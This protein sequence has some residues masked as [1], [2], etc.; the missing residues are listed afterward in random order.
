[1]NPWLTMFQ[2]M[3]PKAG[4]LRV[5]VSDERCISCG[6]YKEVSRVSITKQDG[7]MGAIY[8]CEACIEAIKIMV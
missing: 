2:S 7:M 1:M 4:A 8:L 5:H 6:S 3:L